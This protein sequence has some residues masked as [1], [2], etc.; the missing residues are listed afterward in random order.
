MIWNSDSDLMMVIL[1]TQ[2]M[3]AVDVI[4]THI[5]QFSDVVRHIIYKNYFSFMNFYFIFFHNDDDDAQLFLLL[6]LSFFATK[7][8]K[9]LMPSSV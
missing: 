9:S 8:R 4:M 2:K 1:L 6:S 3:L 5:S 7:R